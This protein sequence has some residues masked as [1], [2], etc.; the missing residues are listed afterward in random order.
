MNYCWFWDLERSFPGYP[1]VRM[2]ENTPFKRKMLFTCIHMFDQFDVAD[3]I[4]GVVNNQVDI[5]VLCFELH[6]VHCVH[7]SPISWQVKTFSSP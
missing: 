7:Y 6:F 4:L 2:F 5:F 3:N 1:Q